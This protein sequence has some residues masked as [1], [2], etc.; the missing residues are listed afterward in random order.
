M[1]LED[2]LATLLNELRHQLESGITTERALSRTMGL[3]Q[4]HV[5]NLLAGRRALTVPVADH[6]LRKLGWTLE[7]LMVAGNRSTKAKN[8]VTE[9]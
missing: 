2:A 3:S 4:S 1:Y 7:T 5:H 8:D 6:I 9:H